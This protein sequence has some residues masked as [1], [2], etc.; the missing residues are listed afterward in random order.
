MIND[1][2]LCL[3]EKY[4]GDDD[5]IEKIRLYV[6]N[7]I[8]SISNIMDY[9]TLFLE[10]ATKLDD[11]LGMALANGMYFWP[12]HGTDIY[13][14]HMYSAK[15]LSI[16]KSIDN[17]QSKCGYLSVLNNEFIFY[18]YNGNM[19]NS[20]E[21]MMEAMGLALENVDLRYYF[22]FS[23]N[24]VYLLMDL[25]LYNKA[26]AVI[27]K[28]CDNNVFLSVADKAILS[29]LKIKLNIRFNNAIEAENEAFKLLKENN[30]NKILDNYIVYSCIVDVFLLEN[31]IDE[32]HKY[33]DLLLETKNNS[34]DTVDLVE[35]DLSLARYYKAIGDL[36]KSEKYF[37]I[38][39]NNYH[40]LLGSKILML[41]DAEEVFKDT[42]NKLYYETLKIK[43]N[44]LLEANKVC[45]RM[46]DDESKELDDFYDLKFKYV[47][48][49]IDSIIEFIDTMN[50]ATSTDSLRKIIIEHVKKITE[51][52]YFDVVDSSY[53]DSI[54][55]L[56]VS[57]M[58]NIKMFDKLSP[59][60][61]DKG[62][63]AIIT[64]I[65][66]DLSTTYWL[67]TYSNKTNIEKKEIV[68]LIK[69]LKEMCYPVFENLKKYYKALADSN[70]DQL[71][72]LHNRYGL[73]QILSNYYAYNDNSYILAMDIDNF[74]IFNDTYGHDCGDEVLKTFANI[75][76][77]FFNAKYAF[78]VGGEEFICIVNSD[79][80]EDLLSKLLVK[81]HNST[82]EYNGQKLKFT[83]SIGG[84]KIKS[85]DELEKAL[86]KADIML[87]KS[88]NNGKDQFNLDYDYLK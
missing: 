70:H 68:Y 43:S 60:L 82:I 61:A 3:V 71:T 81:I 75:L 66:N 5:S 22:V 87:Y 50:N 23:I 26:N 33:I 78:R 6:L 85:F 79:A 25:G 88:K 69:I 9:I 18:N 35:C 86:K 19:E 49:K 37:T 12:L 10:K 40:H 44:L 28:V 13:K 67:F 64:K 84:T 65:D 17:Y 42:N 45:R 57:N 11:K 16:Y 48:N 8:F 73:N 83:V 80:I 55:G 56:D 51:A 27:N 76:I 15:A 14:A 31:K 7:H 59:E 4:H 63:M 29:T 77:K 54:Y 36:K 24:S 1:D 53:K 47:F 20:Y 41:N 39:F 52:N 32:C 46:I 34:S 21:I 30:E 58:E 72:K 2:F 38:C 74:K 62:D